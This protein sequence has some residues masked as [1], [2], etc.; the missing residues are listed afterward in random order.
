MDMVTNKDPYKVLGVS[1]NADAKEI[2]TSYRN[3]VQRYHPDRNSGNEFATEKAQE[4]NWAYDI[5]GNKKK[6]AL[7]DEFGE[8]SLQPGFDAEQARRFGAGMN[9][10]GFHGGDFQGFEGFQGG[11]GGFGDLFSQLF[12]GG[13][14]APTQR[15]GGDLE[16]ELS[17]G[18]IDALQGDERSLRLQ[19][20]T[21]EVRIPAGVKDGQKL[22]LGGLG[23]PGS[24]G[25]PDGDL[26][27]VIK[28]G[29]HPIYRREG[30]H[31]YRGVDLSPREAYEGAR[32]AVQTPAGEVE[33][34][35]PPRSRSGAK[36]R[37]KGLG[38][39]RRGGGKG[40]LFIELAIQTP[41]SDDPRVLELLK[42]L[43]A[44]YDPPLRDA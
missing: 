26:V 32:I 6:R 13:R 11:G 22:R 40:D 38:A 39:P 3:L 9:G 33:L 30:D 15:K 42:E 29:K 44:H 18:F 41:R 43:D 21:V 34:G 14:R 36:L 12:S 2:K 16:T 20:R 1:R 8:L 27:V 23:Q 4:V 37:L 35:V 19:G 17:I 5:L 25:G 7:Y 31:L 28:V 24:H 10:G